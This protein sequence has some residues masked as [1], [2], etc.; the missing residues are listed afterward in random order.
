M[1]ALRILILGATGVF[2]RRLSDR[3]AS[4][5]GLEVILAGRSRRTL[6]AFAG[7]LNLSTE[8]R[9]EICE[10]DLEQPWP[11]CLR[12]RPPDL[13]VN[14]TGPFQ[15]ADYG[16]ART[17]IALGANYVDIA[18][19]RAF[20]DGFRGLD[21]DSR[22]AG[23][24]ALTGASST[25]AISNAVIDHYRDRFAEIADISVAI[26]PGNRSPRGL[27]VIRAILSY[28]GR[29]VRYFGAGRWR[30]AAGWA[31]LERQAMPGLGRRWLSLC[32]VPD[33][34][35]LPARFEPRRQAVFRAGVEL[36]VMHLGLWCLSWLVRWRLVPRLTPFARPLK[37]LADLLYPFGSDLGGMTVTIAGK[38]AGGDPIE[39]NWSLVAAA[40]DGPYVP[41][42]PVVALIRH[43]LAKQPPTAGAAVCLGITDLKDLEA[44]F[45]ELDICTRTAWKTSQPQSLYRRIIG[46]EFDR[47]PRT[48]K[49]LHDGGSRAYLGHAEISGK[50]G[51]LH[52]LLRQIMGFPMNGS[53]VVVEVAIEVEGD[54]EIWTRNFAGTNFS[55]RIRQAPDDP[56][57]QEECFGPL[58]FGFDLSCRGGG[59]DL[60]L[61]R[62]RCLGVAMPAFLG[63]RITGR[64]NEE[65][66]GRFCFDIQIH[67]PL[68]GHLIGYSG[69]LEVDGS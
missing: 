50:A 17:A 45:A 25:P 67:L 65:C 60:R 64:E 6:A 63:P 19:G 51:L 16:V 44:E 3:L 68:L 8:S 48:V 1:S 40:G 47:L 24:F 54:D 43:L 58:C 56:A 39:L 34:D 2:G 32:D 52:R 33:L 23:L 28:C 49:R 12:E 42:L 61:R 53:D 20:V 9:F 21:A 4:L 5:E 15:T 59:L 46:E 30:E 7:T 36:S 38:D 35:I 13:V 18:D 69:C 57:L 22:A 66:P 37:V 27:G 14:T 11:A 31:L 62:W 55:S 26:S 10:F 29:P 41:I